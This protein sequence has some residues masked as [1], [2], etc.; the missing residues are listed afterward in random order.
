MITVDVLSAMDGIR[1]GF[2]T[3]PMGISKGIY[4]GLNCGL[5][6]RD[7]SADIHENR[8]IAAEAMGAQ[9]DQL[10]TLF[11][12]HSPDVITVTD[13]WPHDA[14]P[15]ADGLVTNRRGI[16]LGV[17]AADCA[18][19]LFADP[20]A[21]VIGACHA[22]WRGAIGGVAESTIHA[23]TVL[24]ASRQ[25]ITAIIGPCIGP[26][27][28]EVSDQ[29]K[30][31][32]LDQDTANHQFFR[33]GLPGKQMFDLPGYL[34]HRLNLSGIGAIS[35][36]GL[37]TLTDEERFFSYRRTTLRGEADYGRNISMIML[38]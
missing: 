19:L 11:Q 3:R 34:C 28:Y 16:V 24:G 29:F 12:V 4:Q 26:A 17:L 13:P 30:D 35:W 2:A 32:F 36:C 1:H 33:P 21:G 8:S 22:G 10:V 18:P 5:G 38:P 37:D 6:S 23:M 27:S 31:P 7:I 15:N 25:G 9:P 20:V 14:A